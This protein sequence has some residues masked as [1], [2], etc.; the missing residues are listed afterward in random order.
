MVPDK[1]D[2]NDYPYDPEKVATWKMIYNQETLQNYLLK[3]NSSH[4]GQ[5]HGTPFTMQPLTAIDWAAS[6]DHAKEMLNNR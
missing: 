5:A 2:P 3:R 6:S 1:S 4:F